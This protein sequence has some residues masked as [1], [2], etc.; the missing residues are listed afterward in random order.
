MALTAAIA[1]AA[2]GD[3]QIVAAVPGKKIRVKAYA[4]SNLTAAVQSVKWRSGSTDV[5]GLYGRDASI[6]IIV[7]RDLGPPDFYF[8]TAAGA[9]LNLNLA[10]AVAVG[11]SVQFTLE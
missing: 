7:A 8:E 11:G 9:A 3:N 2:S 4:V 10:A 5:T 6:G 1:A